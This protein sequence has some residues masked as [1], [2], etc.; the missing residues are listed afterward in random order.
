M[1]AEAERLLRSPERKREQKKEINDE[2]GCS[3]TDRPAGRQAGGQAKPGVSRRVRKYVAAVCSLSICG[4]ESVAL[5]Y[6]HAS[7][8]PRVS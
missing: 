1:R 2:V 4:R 8:V 6:M 5:A 7:P 3:S